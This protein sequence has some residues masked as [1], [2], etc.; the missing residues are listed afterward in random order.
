MA[1]KTAVDI[2]LGDDAPANEFHG[3]IFKFLWTIFC[4]KKNY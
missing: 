3:K 1:H 2:S 4:V